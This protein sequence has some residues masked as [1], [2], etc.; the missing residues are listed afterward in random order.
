MT[1][2][3]LGTNFPN[4]LLR[5]K[6]RD[7][8]DLGDKLLMVAT[9]RISAFDVILPSGIPDKGRVLT[10]L[11]AFWFQQTAALLS[12]HFI[13][14]VDRE[15]IES[16]GRGVLGSAPG[17]DTLAGRAMVT[18]KAQRID[19]EC[20][21]RGY[22][23]GSAWAEYQE[24]GAVCGQPLPQGLVE[25]QQLPQ[26][27]FTP[28]GK[29]A[30]GHDIN[31][32][33]DQM[34]DLVGRALAEE[35]REKSLSVYSYADAYARSRGIIIADTKMEFGLLDGKVILIDE[36]LTPDSSRFWPAD[37]YRPGGSQLSFDK[38]F[39]RDWLVRSGWDREPPGPE[40]PAD[41]IEKTAQKYRE[42]YRRLTGEA[43]EE[44]A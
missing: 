15:W 30:E 23:A 29:A 21:V 44:G 19:V 6:V 18:R 41:I 9:D 40:L 26:P 17:L 36:L 10:Q 35:L 7:N 43:L 3:L 8:Y 4:L 32:S 42:I 11:S 5:G 37:Q 27:V 39:V 22:L 33:F 20:V 13:K 38:Q 24:S 2:V 1:D 14:V 12:N 31:I 34:A 25:S 16:E 28:A